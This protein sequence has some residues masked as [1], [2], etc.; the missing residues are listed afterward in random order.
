MYSSN[1]RKFVVFTETF[2][3]IAIIAIIYVIG[4]NF[5]MQK[6]FQLSSSTFSFPL[7]R[8][9][10][11]FKRSIINHTL[12]LIKISLFAIWS[13]LRISKVTIQPGLCWYNQGSGINKGS[14]RLHCKGQYLGGSD[15]F[16]LQKFQTTLFSPNNCTL[17]N[18]YQI[19][20]GYASG[21]NF[22]TN[23]YFWLVEPFVYDEDQPR[24]K[25]CTSMYMYS[26]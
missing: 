25:P 12:M 19:C 23:N 7:Q 6:W 16:K 11:N 5:F 21:A 17:T 8:G 4:I 26:N 3:L 18:F 20:S 22:M 2:V 10:T 15:S 14:S 1:S 13:K 9:N 24:R